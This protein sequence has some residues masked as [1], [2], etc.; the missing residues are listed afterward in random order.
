MSK[1]RSSGVLLHITSL[2]GKYPVGTL[3]EEAY[4]FADCLNKGGQKF[5]QILPFNS[6]CRHFHYS[7]YVATST[8]AGNPLFI[9]PD[10]LIGDFKWAANVSIPQPT[11]NITDPNFVSFEAHENIVLQVLKEVSVIFFRDKPSGDFADY[12][13]FCEDK[14]LWL[15][16]YALYLSLADEF[17]NYN[18]LTWDTDISLRNNSALQHWTSKKNDD[19]NFHKFCQYIFFKQWSDLKQYCNKIKVQII[20]DIP[21][22]IGLESSDAWANPEIFQINLKLKKCD[23]VAGVPPDYFSETG[24]RWGNPLYKWQK[25]GFLRKDTVQWWIKRIKHLLTIVDVLRIDHFRAFDSYWAIP[26]E[27]KTAI[28]G[29]WERGPGLKF[30][31]I[32]KKETGNTEIIAEDLGIITKDVEKLRDRAGLPGMKI[33]QFAFDY[34]PDN[35]YLPSNYNTTNCVVYTGTHDNNTTNGWFYEGDVDEYRKKYILKYMNL[36]D[37]AD[38]NWNLI[39]FGMASIADYAIIPAQDIIGYG[40]KYRMNIP[41]TIEN[42]W[43]WKLSNLSVFE[44]H[45]QKLRDITELYNRLQKT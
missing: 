27:E 26:S 17:N 40:Y 3:G 11:K 32:L 8:F 41:G 25:R 4:R 23:K 34:N 39:K 38:F 28:K 19:I 45:M 5:W 2:P 16:D 13:K 37:D 9:N 7:P 20:G 6:V 12:N 44:T 18:W 15:D 43:I 31:E 30:F 33:L 21:I 35:S 24:Q 14:K 1:R 36:T 42:N 22:Y 10:K 29:K